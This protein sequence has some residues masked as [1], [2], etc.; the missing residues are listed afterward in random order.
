[1]STAAD[2]M[3]IGLEC[4]ILGETYNE[5]RNEKLDKSGCLQCA[6]GLAGHIKNA[7]LIASTGQHMRRKAA[8]YRL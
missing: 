6:E 8:Y 7:F 1:M 5:I 4:R 2:P 3:Q